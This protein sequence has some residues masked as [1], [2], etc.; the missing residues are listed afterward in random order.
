[1]FV[2]EK[3]VITYVDD[4]ILQRSGFED[5]LARL[6]S[7]FCKLTSA[8][9]SINTSKFH[10]WRPE[11]KFLRH[12]ICDRTLRPDLRRIKA[13]L[14]YP[15]PKNQKQLSKSLGICK[16]HHQFIV[17][18][19]QYVAPLLTLLRKRSKWSWSSTMQKAFEEVREKFAQCIYL[20]QPDDTQDYVI[21]TDACVKAIGVV[22]M[23]KDKEGRIN[24]VSTASC[25]LTPAE[26]RYTTCKLE[27]MAIV[28]AFRKLRIYIYGH[29][30]TLNTDHKSLFFFKK[31]VVTSNWGSSLDVRN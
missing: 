1:V 17:N 14:L 6:G 27:L 24:I 13:I 26:Q 21:N 7:V 23:E 8:G 30:V 19:S 22:L 10:P 15:P 3:N 2:D 12:I 29:K 20:V 28:H 16:F 4:I 5:Y 11:I 31:C 18:Y 25:I 9:F